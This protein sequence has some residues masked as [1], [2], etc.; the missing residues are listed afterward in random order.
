MSQKNQP[1]RRDQ[2]RVEATFR[3]E[4]FSGPLPPP[5]L[6]VKYNTAVPDAAERILRMAEA[7]SA[8]RQDIERRVVKSNTLNQTLGTIFG[9]II[10]MGVISGGI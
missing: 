3:G 6:L 8:H 7:Q 4:A 10:A 5:D 9:F 1:A 2:A